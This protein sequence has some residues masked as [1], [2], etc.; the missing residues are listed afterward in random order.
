MEY[1][2]LD[3]EEQPFVRRFFI[4]ASVL[5]SPE[6]EWVSNDPVTVLDNTEYG[7]DGAVL[8]DAEFVERVGES[9]A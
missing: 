2:R 6:H 4:P 1:L 9:R 5:V 3:V 8:S 7:A